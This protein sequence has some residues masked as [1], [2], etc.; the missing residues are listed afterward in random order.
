MP[1]KSLQLTKAEYET[2]ATFRYFLRQF[3]QFSED[4]AHAAGLSPQQHQALLA[5]K[6]FPGRD[7][8]TVGELAERLHI[9]HHSAVGLAN[10][11]VV[12]GLIKRHPDARDRR[13][14]FVALT[15]RGEAML[16]TLSVA[17][18][19]QLGRIAPEIESLLQRLRPKKAKLPAASAEGVATRT[20]K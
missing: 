6:G 19:T 16:A 18:K 5:I 9:R 12:S 7:R 2:L 4:A 1:R 13:Q 15:A 3:L 20:P 14:V 10:R 8:V 17:H 11:L